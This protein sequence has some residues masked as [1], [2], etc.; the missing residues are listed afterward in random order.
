MRFY[1]KFF[2][3]VPLIAIS[4]YLFTLSVDPYSKFSHNPWGL[5]TKAV[6]SDRYNKFCQIDATEETYDLFLLG[7]SRIQAFDPDIIKMQSGLKTY[8]YGVNDAKPEDFLAI[9]KHI[10]STH[11]FTQRSKQ[12]IF[13]QLDFY[14]LNKYIPLDGRLRRSPLYDF[15]VDNT[16]VKDDDEPCY[17]YEKSYM[18]F[19]SFIDAVNVLSKNKANMT[20]V[21]HKD[22][23]MQLGYRPVL[24]PKLATAYFR[25]Q[26][27][28]YTID[29]DRIDDLK[30]ISR[31]CKANDIRLIVS[32]SPM[33]KEHLFNITKDEHLY[34]QFLMF[35]R[36][37]VAIFGEVYDFNNP[38]AFK[39]DFPYWSDSVHPSINLANLMTMTI[40][41]K[42]QNRISSS[43]FGAF[44]TKAN[45]DE[46][47]K[48]VEQEVEKYH[49]NIDK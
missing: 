23:G 19:E 42:K 28:D 20:K 10:I 1:M 29:M 9:T 25:H 8:N 32:L 15:L 36:V 6:S 47:L 33:N 24:E 31:L 17:L 30:E 22:N 41:Q 5:K 45:I 3:F 46:Y 11:P 2:L 26:Y 34:A 39:Y 44:I 35:K 37:V 21:T 14:D 38:S 13:L 43:D 48:R 49:L 4:F 12:I 27:K 40:F 18:T 16:K 7:S